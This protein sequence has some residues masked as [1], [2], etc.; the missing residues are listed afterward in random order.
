MDKIKILNNFVDDKTC[1]YMVNVY[2]TIFKDK[3]KT[4]PD[5]RRMIR[6]SPHLEIV[7]FLKTY[8][9]KLSN[10][11]GNTYYVR[12]LL[13]SIYEEGSYLPSHIDFI[14]EEYFDSLG[15]LFYFNDN[16]TGGEIYFSEL[17]YKYKPQKGSVLI[18]P[19]NNPEYK[20]G[21]TKVTSGIRYT[22]P[23]E[24]TLKEEYKIYRL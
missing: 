6:N 20:H 14:E 15:V 8:I 23:I 5:N 17:N 12:D 1:D 18:F 4:P 13:L 9:K 19:C 21:V 24:I 3:T 7:S 16:F 22:M 11:L 10:T 2:K